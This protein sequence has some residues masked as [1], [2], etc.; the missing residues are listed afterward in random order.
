[1]RT[2]HH[3]TLPPNS[4]LLAGRHPP[5]PSGFQSDRL[6]IWWNNTAEGWAD[7]GEH[8]HRDS[9]EIFVVLEG[10]LV[11][12][13][14]GARVVVSAGEYCCFPAGLAHAVVA[15]DPPLRTLMIRA[16]SIQDKES[17]S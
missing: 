6:Q 16:P 17:A 14:E 8:I 2:F 5:N 13:V 11:I 1:M 15:T 3:A 7:D 4:D 12:T 10:S 9:D